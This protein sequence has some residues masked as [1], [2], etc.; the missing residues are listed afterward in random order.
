MDKKFFVENNSDTNQVTSNFYH[1]INDR[2]DYSFT[3]DKIVNDFLN[4]DVSL[5]TL[6]ENEIFKFN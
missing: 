3:S 4:K 1:P 5:E 6:I 2:K